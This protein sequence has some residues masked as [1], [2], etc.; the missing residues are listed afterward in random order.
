MFQEYVS[1]RQAEEEIKPYLPLFKQCYE[2]AIIKY[3]KILTAYPEPLFQR[4]KAIN[5]QNIIVNE[6]KRA[7]SSLE[8]CRIIEKYESISLLINDYISARFKK[9]N[10]KGFPSNHRSGRNDLIIAQ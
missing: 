9:L 6:I 2:E 10:K 1:Q 8:N 5:F 4:T 3:A 7:F